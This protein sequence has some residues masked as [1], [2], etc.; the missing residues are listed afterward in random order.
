MRETMYETGGI[1]LFF[2]V[3]YSWKKKI[4]ISKLG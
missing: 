2:A 3:D 1:F 4:E